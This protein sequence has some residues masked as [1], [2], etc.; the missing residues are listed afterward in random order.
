VE[1]V[2]WVA[3]VLPDKV[4]AAKRFFAELEGSRRREL[5]LA[6]ERLGFT[7]EIV[8]LT[9]VAGAPALVFYM[10]GEAFYDS[11]S[12]SAGSTHEFDRWYRSRLEDC[13]GIDLNDPPPN[14]ELLMAYEAVDATRSA[15][16][17]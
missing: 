16:P 9:D 5:E 14:A 8:F 13:T 3:P 7:K 10:E 6:E 2:C 4:E 15:G 12:T 1:R 11:V 17:R